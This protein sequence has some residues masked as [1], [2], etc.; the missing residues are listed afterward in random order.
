MAVS[1]TVGNRRVG[2][3]RG[4]HGDG[5]DEVGLLTLAGLQGT[6]LVARADCEARDV[7]L[8]LGRNRIRIGRRRSSR[9]RGGVACANTAIVTVAPDTTTIRNLHV[10]DADLSDGIDRAIEQPNDD[11]MDACARTWQYGR[12]GGRP[13]KTGTPASEEAGVPSND[14][15]SQIKR[16]RHP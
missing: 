14:S 8:E 6:Q 3:C 4:S 1:V 9:D 7:Q 2:G 15:E 16:A 10:T 13:H 12:P 11:E 5:T